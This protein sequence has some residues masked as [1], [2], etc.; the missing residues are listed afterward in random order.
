MQSSF[1]V[2][3]IAGI[4]IGIHYTWLFAF[5]LVT[6]SLADGFLPANYPGWALQTYWS[7]G[8]VTALLLFVSVLIHELSHSFVARARGIG[9]DSITLFIFGGVSNLTTESEQPRDEFLIAVVGPLTSFVL[10]GLAWLAGLAFAAGDGALGAMLSYLTTIN[11]MLGIFNLVP[12]FP[13]DGGR[14]LRSIVWGVTGSVRR[15]TEIASFVGQ[16]VGFLLIFWGVGRIFSGDF[17]GGLWTGFIGWFLNGAAEATRHAVAVRESLRGVS[18]ATLMD[19][20][21]TVVAPWVSVGDFVFEHVLRRGDRAALVVDDGRLIGIV[22]I[23][24]IKRVPQEQWAVT[25]LRQIMTPA[26]LKTI[27]PET[28][29]SSALGLLVEGELNQLPVVNQGRLVGMLTRANVLQFLQLRDE[30][31]IR[32]A[33]TTE[34]ALNGRPLGREHAT[35]TGPH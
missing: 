8:A 22:S 3:R 25:P 30:L 20:N 19:P 23:I 17:L 4:T 11:L 13:L 26:P 31:R 35:V 27:A 28:D 6:W 14:V 10:A 7:I 24:D 21:P 29:L 15:A 12:G 33:V 32:R 1:K 16:G 5:F 2:G 34:A 18:V 9:V